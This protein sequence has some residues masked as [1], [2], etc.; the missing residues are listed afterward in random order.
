MPAKGKAD[1]EAKAALT[2][3]PVDLGKRVT[4]FSKQ[5]I[6]LNNEN[7]YQWLKSLSN[8]IY[9]AK[10]PKGTIDITGELPDKWD[11]A[12]EADPV[13]GKCAT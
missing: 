1:E 13:R 11:G 6:I 5:L 12:E 8:L 3:T 7:F 10:W 9:S 2:G 4:T